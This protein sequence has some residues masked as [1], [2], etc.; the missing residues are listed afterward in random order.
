MRVD[1]GGKFL[2]QLAARSFASRS[3]I[4]AGLIGLLSTTSVLAQDDESKA[5][6]KDKKSKAVA[7]SDFESPKF[8]KVGDEPIS[9]DSPGY[10]CPT[11][12]DLDGDGKA[13][14]VVGQF[15]GGYIKFYKNEADSD[16]APSFGKG[17]WLKSGKKKLEIP[18]VS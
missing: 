1:I 4:L 16:Q 6:K 18:G 13:D 11:M 9:V 14:L 2:V 8:L 10:A 15:R 3:A 5:E 17:E 7:K 12:A